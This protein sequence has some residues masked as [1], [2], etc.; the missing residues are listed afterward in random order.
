MTGAES[1]ILVEKE[2]ED[3]AL[4]ARALSSNDEDVSAEVQRSALEALQQLAK[5]DSYTG[6][7]KVS[8]VQS[9]FNV[10]TTVIEE[11]LK[12]KDSVSPLKRCIL[13]I[14]ALLEKANQTPMSCSDT[15]WPMYHGTMVE[16]IAEAL[17][18]TATQAE[19]R[20]FDKICGEVVKTL[21]GTQQKYLVA[22]CDVLSKL[23]VV[24]GKTVVP[25]TR[26]TT[27]A[28]LNIIKGIAFH[29]FFT[30]TDIQTLARVVDFTG[31]LV[32]SREFAVTATLMGKLMQKATDI[33]DEVAKGDAS[34]I[35]VLVAVF[36]ECHEVCSKMPEPMARDLR[37]S[38]FAKKFDIV[39][40]V[41]PICAQKFAELKDF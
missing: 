14:A 11:I 36:D 5:N 38:A 41:A 2:A 27:Q 40:I 23:L 33:V 35:A 8:L 22:A 21:L 7:L 18:D 4:L 3:L 30:S 28:L 16:A 25:S 31:H 20:S 37:F 9:E 39:H 6:I 13:N 34:S 29:S 32:S 19:V 10:V 1:N 24:N 26:H 12:K 17:K 15:D